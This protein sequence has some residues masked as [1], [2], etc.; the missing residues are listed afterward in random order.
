MT[1]IFTAELAQK[2]LFKKINK[3]VVKKNQFAHKASLS[4]AFDYPP[5]GVYWRNQ[6]SRS[7]VEFAI[8]TG[9]YRH[10]RPRQRLSVFQPA[11]LAPHSSNLDGIYENLNPPMLRLWNDI[12]AH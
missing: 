1:P 7:R 11:S 12:R 9:S 5:Y 4:I 10:V 8:A 3:Y 2:F 6:N